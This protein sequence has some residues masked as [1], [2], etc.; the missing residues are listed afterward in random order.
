MD[1]INEKEL[2]LYALKNKLA[3]QKINDPRQH[4]VL[5]KNSIVRIYKLF[6]QF[7]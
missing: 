1:E 3:L 6:I 7:Y 5:I 2:E 4:E